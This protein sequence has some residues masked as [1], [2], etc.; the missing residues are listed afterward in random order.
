M[1]CQPVAYDV[2]WFCDRSRVPSV[3]SVLLRG[4]LGTDAYCHVPLLI[5]GNPVVLVGGVHLSGDGDDSIPASSRVAVP[6]PALLSH[7]C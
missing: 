2:A 7:I 1:Q 5:M 4:V 3:R 6:P